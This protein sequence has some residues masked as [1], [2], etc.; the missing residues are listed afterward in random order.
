MSDPSTPPRRASL[1]GAGVTWAAFR[2]EELPPEELRYIEL[3]ALCR[4]RGIDPAAP[5]PVL[6]ERLQ[7]LAAGTGTG[8]ALSSSDARFASGP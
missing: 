7:G 6:L 4:A 2:L 1:P 5:R 3:R 8:A